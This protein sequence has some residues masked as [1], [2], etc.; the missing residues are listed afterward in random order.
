MLRDVPIQ[1]RNRNITAREEYFGSEHPSDLEDDN[2]TIIDQEEWNQR[3]V[4][5]LY[6]MGHLSGSRRRLG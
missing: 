3:A 2:G 6:R 1:V 5:L 4:H